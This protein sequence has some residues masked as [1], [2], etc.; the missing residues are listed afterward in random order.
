MTTT[1]S[2]PAIRVSQADYNLLQNL[3][4][5]QSG[6]TAEEQSTRQQLFQE[7]MRARIEPELP[8]DVIAL[9]SRARLLDIESGDEME[10]TLVLPHEADVDSGRLSILAPLGTAMLG[11]CRGAEFQWR[12]PGGTLNLRVLKVSQG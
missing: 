4:A 11:F 10:F 9:R 3:L 5:K 12:M 8:S 7:L 2:I 1:T 6:G